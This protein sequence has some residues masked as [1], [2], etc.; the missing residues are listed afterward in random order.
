MAEDLSAPGTAPA[1]RGTF[2]YDRAGNR[3][4]A[5]EWTLMFAGPHGFERRLLVR[6]AI[7][8]DREIC[9]L[10]NGMIDGRSGIRLYGSAAMQ[11]G[12]VN[13]WLADYDSEA[14]AL[15]GHGDLVA[16]IGQRFFCPACYFAS[17][18]IEDLRHGWCGRCKA[19]TGPLW[20]QRRFRDSPPQLG[21]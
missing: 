18:N 17:P 1:E 4:T 8:R 19:N 10:W 7:S 20:D 21:F 2:F 5:Q 16:R 12:I 3:I 14:D 15:A 9:T 13:D 6:T 11:A